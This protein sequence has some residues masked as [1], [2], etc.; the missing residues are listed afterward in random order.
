MRRNHPVDL[1]TITDIHNNVPFYYEYLGVSRYWTYDSTKMRYTRLMGFLKR[2]LGTRLA[3][4]I[5][6]NENLEDQKRAALRAVGKSVKFVF[7]VVK[8]KDRT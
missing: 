4:R 8:N 6:K 1:E 7:R 5:L 2:K 3:N